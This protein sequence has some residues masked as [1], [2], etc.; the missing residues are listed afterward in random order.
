[1]AVGL[2]QSP[3]LFRALTQS[4]GL[5]SW[6]SGQTRTLGYA[7]RVL[8]KAGGPGQILSCRWRFTAAAAMQEIPGCPRGRVAEIQ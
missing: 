2:L 6:N 4:P 3:V 1:M 5:P 7:S 8:R